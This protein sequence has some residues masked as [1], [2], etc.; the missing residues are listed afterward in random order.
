[1]SPAYTACPLANAHAR[2]QR[3]P[4]SDMK[5]G[6]TDWL[7][8]ARPPQEKLASLFCRLVHRRSEKVPGEPTAMGTGSQA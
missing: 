1:M 6:P 3:L 8:G 4:L 7:L 5:G 2:R